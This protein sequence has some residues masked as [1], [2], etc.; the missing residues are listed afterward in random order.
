MKKKQT[1][2]D[3]FIPRRSG[4]LVGKPSGEAFDEIPERALHTGDNEVS[5]RIGEARQGKQL[6]VDDLTESLQEID[7]ESVEQETRKSR[8]QRR[9]AI[10]KAKKDRPKSKVRRILKWFGIVLLVAILSVGGYVLYKA[11]IAGESAFQGGFLGIVQHKELKM[12]ENGR[13]NFLI[14]GSSEDDPGHDAPWL[15]DSIMIISVDQK[16]NDVYMFSVPRD[17]YVDYGG[18]ACMTGYRG[19]I[20]TY[21]SCTN[22]G[23]DEAAEQDRL[24]KTQ[25]FIGDIYGLDIQ[26]GV[27]VNYTVMRDLVNAV[28]G[29]ITVNIESRNPLGVMDSNFDWK[30][31]E[32]YQQ[33]IANCPPDGHYIQYPNG[34]VE[35]DAEHA[36]YL[37]Q[38]RGDKAPTYGFEQSNFDRERNQQKIAVAIRDKALS[39]GTLTNV[40]AVTG[41]IDAL[42]NNLRTNIQTSEIRTM[43]DVAMKTKNDDIHSL[44]FFA[45][46][47]ILY[48]TGDVG[49]AGS[50][51]YPAAG[52]YVYDDLRAFV[53]QSLSSDPIV[54]EAPHVTVLNAS[55]QAGIAQV[56]ADALAEKGF[57]IDEVGNAPEGTFGAIEIYQMNDEKPESGKRLKKLYGVKELKTSGLDTSIVGATDYVI[58]ISDPSAGL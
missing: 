6:G 47:N 4:N 3:G 16:A 38:A 31:G 55:D 30:C 14:V 46:D 11:I 23:T 40:G 28:G 29:S 45:D 41:L 19:K 24:T 52:L 13:S 36:L 43:M 42:G 12:D 51:V 53:K 49:T 9:K 58:V 17:L 26:Y 35:L 1:S 39:A 50:S 54:R 37:A 18:L 48:D 22:D 2:I 7:A 56:Q 44:D 32:T 34:S 15:T 25:K 10:K 27:H 33:R 20:N 21:F 5:E 8:R 57:V